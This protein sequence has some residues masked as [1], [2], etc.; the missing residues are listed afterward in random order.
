M[1]YCGNYLNSLQFPN[2]K[3]YSFRIVVTSEICNPENHW[4]VQL[5]TL[6]AY[7]SILLISM[8]SVRTHFMRTT[9]VR[10]KS[11]ASAELDS[12]VHKISRHP[13]FVKK[14]QIANLSIYKFRVIHKI[15][16]FNLVQSSNSKRTKSLE[17]RDSD[18]V[19]FF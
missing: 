11:G 16:V 7:N 9:M 18:S 13:L 2:S 10:K 15:R 17:L 6:K 8:A 14:R 5:E 3:N 19:H 12:I 1:K 4:I